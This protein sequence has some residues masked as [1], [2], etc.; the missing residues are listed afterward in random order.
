VNLRRQSKINI[1]GQRQIETSRYVFLEEE[2]SFQGSRES[3]M[4]IDNE[5][6]PSPPSA[7]QR[8]TDVILID[9]VSPVDMIRDILVGH[10]IPT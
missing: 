8:E 3:H 2:I 9:L 5:T 4:D 1:P 7:V 10:K 6:I